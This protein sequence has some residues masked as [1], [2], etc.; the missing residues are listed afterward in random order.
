M[1]CIRFLHNLTCT[2]NSE[3]HV[4]FLPFTLQRHEICSVINFNGSG[5]YKVDGCYFN[6]ST[7]KEKKN[8]NTVS[9]FSKF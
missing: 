5:M 9:S 6:H 3:I 2:V 7:G 8:N 1:Y 4:L